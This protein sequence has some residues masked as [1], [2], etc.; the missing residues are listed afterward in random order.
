LVLAGQVYDKF[1]DEAELDAL[2]EEPRN[3]I[4]RIVR[5]NQQS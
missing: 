2:D 5:V 4:L 1:V 3:F